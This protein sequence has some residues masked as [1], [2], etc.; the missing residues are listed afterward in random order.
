MTDPSKSVGATH[1]PVVVMLGLSLVFRSW[2]SS[3][4]VS[5]ISSHVRG[6]YIT[7]PVHYMKGKDKSMNQKPRWVMKIRWGEVVYECK[8]LAY[9]NCLCYLLFSFSSY[10]PIHIAG[11]S[12]LPVGYVNE[13]GPMASAEFPF[14]EGACGRGNFSDRTAIPHANRQPF[15]HLE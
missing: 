3:P 9:G 6:L 1:S 5:P 4:S 15:M 13:N 10:H 12:S 8:K 7:S 14:Q 11:D 2:L